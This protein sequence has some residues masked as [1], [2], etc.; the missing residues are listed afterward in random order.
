M[1]SCIPGMH[2][3]DE[4][5]TFTPSS[6]RRRAIARPIPAVEAVTIATLPCRPFIVSP[7]RCS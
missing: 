5:M 7:R 1:A 4:I 3:L 6:A 2:H